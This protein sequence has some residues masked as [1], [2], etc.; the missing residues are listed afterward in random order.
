MED[1]AIYAGETKEKET[2]CPRDFQKEVSVA[3]AVA[4][5]TPG[6]L[7]PVDNK[8]G[9][10]AGKSQSAK[11]S[12]PLEPWSGRSNQ[13][14]NEELN[15]EEMAAQQ[16]K[17]NVMRSKNLENAL[18]TVERAVMQNMYHAKQLRYR[19]LPNATYVPSS[20]ATPVHNGNRGND[21]IPPP[22][23]LSPNMGQE[24]SSP[25]SPHS[26]SLAW[27]E[28]GGPNGNSQ[29]GEVANNEGA[30][31]VSDLGE[32]SRLVPLFDF[33]CSETKG[34]TVICFAIFLSD[35]I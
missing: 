2:D 22:S 7:L 35:L 12:P 6:A 9:V 29:A 21:Y 8:E 11:G 24:V 26:P 30:G 15:V 16:L 17:D 4:L 27:S 23:P 14:D 25:M 10:S 33:L 31:S 1:E 19:G 34:R 20:D 32:K 3:V 28:G 18:H 5:A 13:S